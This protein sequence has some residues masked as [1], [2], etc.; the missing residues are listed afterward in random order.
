MSYKFKTFE[1]LQQAVA[2]FIDERDWAQF[3]NPKNLAMALAVEAAELMELLQWLDTEAAADLSR[4]ETWL[5]RL[6]EELADVLIYCASFA[7]AIG[8]DLGEIAME[9]VQRNKEKYPIETAKKMVSKL[10]GEISS[11]EN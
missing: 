6:S 2:N 1:E 5:G 10:K 11:G 4:Y 8:V 7:N 9:K 3:H